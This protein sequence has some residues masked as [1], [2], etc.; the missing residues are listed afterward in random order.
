MT[1][2]ERVRESLKRKKS[3]AAEAARLGLALEEYL[4]LKQ[5]VALTPDEIYNFQGNMRIETEVDSEP[6]TPE[7]IIRVLKLD[8]SR[9]K[10]SQYWNKQKKNKWLVSAMVTPISQKDITEQTFLE[11]LAVHSVPLIKPESPTNYIEAKHLETVCGVLSL[12]DLHIGKAGNEDVGGVVNQAIHYLL[13]RA[14]KCYNLSQLILVIGPDMLNMDTFYG[15]TTKGTITENSSMAVDAY[16]E[17]YD[18]LANVVRTLKSYCQHLHIVF[19][20]GNHDRLSSFH[21]L[22]ACAQA[23]QQW[24]GVTFDIDYD[25]RKVVK[26]G[27]NFLAIEHGD[28]TVKNNPL[29]YAVEYPELWGQTRHRILYT[30][31][32]HSRKTREILTENEERGFIS[33]TLPALTASDYWHYHHKYVGSKRSAMLHIHDID[34]GFVAE[35]TCNC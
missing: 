34:K 11:R 29:V 17:A 22:H 3:N 30:G 33:R 27:A 16:V 24:D 2:L 26:Y 9:W 8:T 25:E 12:Q 1:D 5:Q 14:S 6:K 10:L 15:T 19:I 21:L 13:Q 20:A 23:F 31:H 32:F 4:Y 28:V 7:E 18:I 35:F